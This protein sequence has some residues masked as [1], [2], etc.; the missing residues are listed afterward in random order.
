MIKRIFDIISSF[1][2]I[3]ILSPVLLI[4]SILIKIENPGKIFFLQERV[5]KNGKLFKIIKFRSMVENAVN[6][7]A[8]LYMDGENDP[9]ITKMGRFIR[10][11]SIDELP[12]LFNI[13]KGDMSVVGPR[14]LLEI[15]TDQ[16]T[17]NQKRRIEVKP[18]ITGW[19]QINGRNEL[20]MKSRIEKDIWYIENQ[21]FFLDLK[22]ILKTIKV[23]LFKEG[24][25]MDQK[26]EDVEKF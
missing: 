14:P 23:V 8:G 25:K 10:K 2:G 13:I 22:I 6:L 16:M 3:I 7:G 21:N 5:G 9:R 4:I 11:T 1:C 18:G 12:Q 15:T 24:I 20:D 26:K 17:R 19:A